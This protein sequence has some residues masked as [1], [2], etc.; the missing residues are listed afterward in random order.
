MRLRARLS[1]AV[2]ALL[3]ALLVFAR[4]L[5]SVIAPFV[6]AL[7]WTAIIDPVVDRLERAGIGRALGA[8]LVLATTAIILIGGLWVMLANLIGE[9]EHLRSHLPQYTQQLEHL[10]ED[11]TNTVNSIVA[12]IPAPFDE[13]LLAGVHQSAD[14][15]AKAASQ[16]LAKASSIP[17]LLLMGTVAISTTYFLSRDK[18]RLGAFFLSLLPRA[19][20]PEMRRLKEE[21][22]SGLLGFV[23]AQAILIVVSGLLSVGGLLLFKVPYAWTLG[24]FAGILDLAP[25]VGPSGVFIPVLLWL[26]ASA[27][28]SRAIG[29]MGVWLLILLVRQLLEPHVVGRHVGLHPITS[30]A[31]MYLG[32]TLVG[33]DGILL[34]PIVAI[35]VKAVCTVSLIPHLKRD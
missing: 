11:W 8:L 32:G 22:A 20:H 18:R 17:I 2:G 9:A 24:T 7:L 29:L 33:I 16:L 28:W 30:I 27:Q 4:P 14:L 12:A 23:R 25:M 34:G 10:I 3:L 6:L 26:W 31:A 1:I 5:L 15:V 21:I 19:W 35:A 13:A